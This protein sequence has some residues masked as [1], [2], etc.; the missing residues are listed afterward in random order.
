[1]AGQ[2]LLGNSAQVREDGPGLPLPHHRWDNHT[3]LLLLIY[4]D[5]FLSFQYPCPNDIL[6]ATFA[7]LKRKKNVFNYLFP[8]VLALSDCYFSPPLS[9]PSTPPGLDWMVSLS[10]NTVFLL[11]T[12]QVSL[13]DHIIFNDW[14]ARLALYYLVLCTPSF[15]ALPDRG[16]GYVISVV[17]SA[18]Q[19]LWSLMWSRKSLVSQCLFSQLC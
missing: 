17:H 5:V 16:I 3:L 15:L 7:E 6:R 13:F 10:P 1:M 14:W 19:W 8:K 9:L 18:E 11:A 4:T 2:F 12:L